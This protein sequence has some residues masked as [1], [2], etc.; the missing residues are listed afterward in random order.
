MTSCTER[1]FKVRITDVRLVLL[2]S[3]TVWSGMHCS[4]NSLLYN[5]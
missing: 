1:H 2:I 5:P 3:G 4:Q